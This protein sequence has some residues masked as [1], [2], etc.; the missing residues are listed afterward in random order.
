[1]LF[2]PPLYSS[3]RQPP[4]FSLAD[5][6]VKADQVN[7]TVKSTLDIM[8]QVGADLAA[9]KEW[10][11][12]LPK[13]ADEAQKMAANVDNLGKCTISS[14]FKYTVMPLPSSFPYLIAESETESYNRFAFIFIISMSTHPM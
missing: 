1:M 13:L 12:S 14:L 6:V 3:L 9:S 5:E 8:S 7:S 10:A 4:P 11:Q 2:L